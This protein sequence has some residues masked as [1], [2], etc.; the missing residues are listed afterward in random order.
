[1]RP[2]IALILALAGWVLPLAAQKIS[3]T[4]TPTAA[5]THWVDSVYQVMSE[6]ERLGQL[7]MI[8]AHSDKGPEHTALVEEQIRKYKVGGLC[9]FQGTPEKQIELTNRYQSL[10]RF[11]LMV[12]I[13]G[14]W[15][16]GMRMVASTMSFP[17]QMMLG[18]IQDNE[19]L[20]KMGQE[21]ARQCR[22]I[23]ITVNFAPDTDINNNGANPVINYRS[24]GEDRDNVAAKSYLYMKGMQDNGVLASAKHFPGHGD[25]NTDSHFD[26]PAINHDIRHLDSIELY[27]FRSLIENGV[28]SVMVA[29]LHV[30]ALDDRPNRPT[31]LSR[32]TIT[33][34]LRRSLNFQGLV[35]SDAMEM[36][37]VT[38]NFSNGLAEAEAILAGIDILCLPENI[39]AAI[40][41]IKA[42]IRDGKIDKEQV[43]ESVRRILRYKFRLGLTK[44]VPISAENVR[45]ELTTPAAENLKRELIKSALTMVRN[46][47]RLVPFGRLDTTSFASLSIGATAQTT[48][49]NR[50]AS[51]AKMTHLQVEK[52]LSEDRQ[53]Q[54]LN[55]LGKFKVVVV[56]LHDMSQYAAKNFGLTQ[57]TIDFVKKLNKRTRVVLTVFGSPYCLKYFDDFDWVLDAYDGEEMVQD[58]A[59]QALFGAF[60]LHGRLPV[61]ASPIS[62]F[63]SGV[64]T[65]TAARFG[66]ALPEAVGMSMDTLNRIDLVAQ[67]AINSGAVP[68]CVVLVAKDGQIVFEKAY[69]YHTYGKE[70]P[71]QVSDIFDL[72]SL[73]KV[74]ATTLSIMQLTEAGKVDIHRPLSE[75]LPDLK[76]TNK[77][78][79]VVSDIMAHYA[80]LTNWLPFY[81]QTLSKEPEFIGKPSY[82]Y[83]R[84]EPTDS[85]DVPVAANLFL[86]HDYMDSVMHEIRTSD[87][88]PNTNYKYSDLGFYLF[89]K[90]V[91]NQTGKPLNVFAEESFY[92]PL[93]LQNTCFNPSQ[94]FPINR[95]PP[96]EEDHYFR[97]Q[98]VQGYVHDMGAAMLGGV[99]GHAGLFA[100]ANDLAV[101]MQMLLQKG[102]YGRHR[103]FQ[104]QTVNEFT[105]RHQRSARRGM[106]FDMF[107]LGGT[108]SNMSSL[109][110]DR[111]FGHTGFTGTCAWVD[112]SSNL[113]YIFLSNRT[114]PSMHNT[115]LE[116]LDI[117]QRIQ[118][119]V[120]KS[121]R[122]R[123]VQTPVY[124]SALDDQD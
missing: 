56:G 34:L 123:A 30:P 72:A 101:I 12:A 32:N 26:L 98:R 46:K 70:T 110:S 54:L 47:D 75:F 27:P 17:R 63:N 45:A 109:A 36:K 106:G 42:Y 122:G 64:E 97:M 113:V 90:M 78:W 58:L 5:E 2:F 65:S 116:R 39:E 95:M 37:G 62:P 49:Q 76:G 10:S 93:G 43:E 13:D 115:R 66:Y 38:K 25:T 4:Q 28:G 41:Q 119:V 89:A 61:T 92:Q 91:Q 108:P 121:I 60:G 105:T 82:Q 107:P 9:F 103:F 44:Y 67:E 120:Y 59:A 117:R 50:L 112:P 23:G 7:M 88:R 68:G 11:P 21:I 96:T 81:K 87:L 100:S 83:Y 31:T 33:E 114:Y 85:F 118:S 79:M 51:Y 18:A 19:L 24:F 53:T 55:Q 8:R 15:G 57:S 16:L 73:T 40:T 71:M 86:R 104:P 124:L 69:G 48:F 80:G 3:S 111:T 1:M 6:D 74:A 20:Y 22:R 14:E 35:F 77:N 102:Y 99:S 84:Y 52:E 94:R 29:H